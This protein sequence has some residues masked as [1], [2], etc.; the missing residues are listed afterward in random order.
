MFMVTRLKK[1]EKD[2][3]SADLAVYDFFSSK[4]KT[5]GVI[6]LEVT[7]GSKGIVTGFYVINAETTYNA[8]F[9][10]DW[11]HKHIC[12]PST[13]HQLLIFW[14][15]DEIE[16]FIADDKPLRPQL[17]LLKLLIMMNL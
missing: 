6:S 14:N 10:S 11:I 8:I 16:V 5:M 7:V 12:I 3:L 13:L 9:G 4:K 1:A 2:I 17:M 15:G